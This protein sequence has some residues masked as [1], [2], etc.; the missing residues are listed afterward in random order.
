MALYQMSALPMLLEFS[1]WAH[2]EHLY[3]N[4]VKRAKASM[5]HGGEIKALLW[6][7]GESDTL[8][9]HCAE[10]YK[11]NMEKL[12]HNVRADCIFHLCQLF[13]LQL[14]QVMRSILKRFDKRKRRLTS[15]MLYVLDAMGL[16]LK[17]DNL[18][19]T[20][21]AQVKL[22]QMLA[23]AYLAHFAPQEPCVASS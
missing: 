19:L 13:R 9:Q 3:V 12:I 22:G 2:E 7:Q 8:S 1:E 4:M 17:E 5:H 18:H 14:H 21:E 15:Q 23:D 10:T 6:Y 20:T 11:A 16:Q